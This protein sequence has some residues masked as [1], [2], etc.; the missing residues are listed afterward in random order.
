MPHSIWATDILNY[1]EK[2]FLLFIIDKA[3]RFGKDEEGFTLTDSEFI[4]QGFGR[5]KAIIRK[6]RQ[7]LVDLGLIEYTKGHTGKGS[8]Y[9][10]KWDNI[11]NLP[12]TEEKEPIDEPKE[13]NSTKVPPTPQKPENKPINMGEAGREEVNRAVEW[14]RREE[15]RHLTTEH[16][17]FYY[18]YSSSNA[19]REKYDQ[20]GFSI[21]ALKEAFAYYRQMD[22]INRRA[23]HKN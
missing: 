10:L 23:I 17:A 16:T 13:E 21:A 19:N 5:D 9:L 11:W 4:K 20:S 22:Y 7:R 2:H 6:A 15:N 8:T 14:F 18:S 12:T 3:N 1:N